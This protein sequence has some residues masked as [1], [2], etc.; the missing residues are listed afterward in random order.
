[1]EFATYKFLMA[2]MKKWPDS[3]QITLKGPE[4]SWSRDKGYTMTPWTLCVFGSPDCDGDSMASR[5]TAPAMSEL[6][7]QLGLQET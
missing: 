4:H 3:P 1:M 6:Y 2:A 7:L 5:Y